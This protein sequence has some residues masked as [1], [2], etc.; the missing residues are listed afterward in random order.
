MDTKD[1]ERVN[2]GHRYGSSPYNDESHGLAATLWADLRRKKLPKAETS[3]DDAWYEQEQ[4]ERRLLAARI[5]KAHNVDPNRRESW[6]Q[7]YWNS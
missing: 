5:G 7:R 1:L 4:E 3:D 2:W 6:R